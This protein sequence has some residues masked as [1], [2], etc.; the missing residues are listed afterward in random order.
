MQWIDIE[1]I[2]KFGS[3]LQDYQKIG[4]LFFEQTHR[5]VCFTCH[6]CG[7]LHRLNIPNRSGLIN[8]QRC[9]ATFMYS[10]YFVADRFIF[11]EQKVDWESFRGRK[12]HERVEEYVHDHK[13]SL[14]DYD[15][16]GIPW[17]R[18]A[19]AIKKAYRELC[20]RFHPDLNTGL[21]LRDRIA[22]EEKM[23]EINRAYD[24]LMRTLS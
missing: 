19:A 3:D 7:T 14:T 10:Y 12:Q 21:P 15:I 23:K 4:E 1:D 22:T 11:V 5:D 16:L 20:K 24:A 2:K 8:C 18:N 13:T 9:H 6:K 17:T